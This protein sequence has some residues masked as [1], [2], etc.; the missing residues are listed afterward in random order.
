MPKRK[1]APR[2]NLPIYEMFVDDNDESGIRY[3]SIVDDPAIE[4]QGHYFNNHKE[5][6]HSQSDAVGYTPP[7]HEYCLCEMINGEWI[8][9]DDACEFCVNNKQFYD[10][11]NLR[12]SKQ[13]LAAVRDQQIIVG[14]IMI[15]DQMIYRK[16]PNGS[17][18]YLTYSA[19]TIKKIV[20][21][22]AKMSNNRSI[23]LMHSS[24]LVKGY[25]MESWIVKDS[26]YDGSKAYGF[27]LPVGTFFG[28]VQV[29]DE[30]FWN[31]Q[32]KDLGRFSFSI[33]GMFP[34]KLLQ[35]SV[36]IDS[37]KVINK[38]IDDLTE[39]EL[40]ALLKNILP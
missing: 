26:V 32:V 35:M 17:E 37:H 23:N 29:E 5:H 9:N 21:K 13:K 8:I 1:K 16:D 27:D 22:F 40:I 7:C 11:R 2:E 31:E 10:D 12:L 25:I 28:A 30:T 19:D 34:T 18:Y 36:Q 6:K 38:Y 14:P 3:I 24:E 4:V 15:P 39:E 33:E 20:Q